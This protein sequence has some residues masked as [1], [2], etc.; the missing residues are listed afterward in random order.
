[1]EF[2]R[3]RNLAEDTSLTAMKE[4]TSEQL[5]TL[6]ML[7]IASVAVGFALF[8]LRPVMVPFVLA[9]MLSYV[10]RPPMD[11]MVDKARCPPWLA[12]ILALAMGALA[13]TLIGA[14]ISGSVRSLAKN[15]SL[16]ES[17][18]K[19]L[20][21]KISSA[22]DS[23]GLE[24]SALTTSLSELPVGK[25]VLAITNGVIDLLSNAFLILVFTIYLLQGN[26]STGAPETSLRV[27]IDEQIKRYINLK[28]WLSAITGTLTWLIL[29]ALG[30]Q[31]ATVFGVMA[32]ILN[33]VPNVGSLVA[34]ALPLPLVVVDPER[35]WG[36]IALVLAL[37]GVVQ[38]IVGNIIEPKMAGDSLDL[39]P[40]T[41]LL[42]LI[43]WGMLWGLAGMLLA[44]PLTAIAR[45]ILAQVPATHPFAELMAGRIHSAPA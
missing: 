34:V 14:L 38:M 13:L 35:S 17:Q 25:V 15:A 36:S 7:A 21:T 24:T 43:V 2:A 9:A 5:Q 39:H 26:P 16:Y 4:T 22:L 44:T 30:V 42:A 19:A 31:L 27:Q 10:L 37:P 41:V 32:F 45:L 28:I 6:C 12:M 40:I 8:W 18:A 1:M 3:L 11:W 33:F 23:Q 20:I 29:W